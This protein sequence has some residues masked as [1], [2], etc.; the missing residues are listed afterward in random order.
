M[1]VPIAS[2]VKYHGSI[3][4]MHEEYIVDDV[5]EDGRFVLVNWDGETLR[6]VRRES[7]TPISEEVGPS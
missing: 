4:D 1:D 3:V 2:L 5:M 6:G 7:I